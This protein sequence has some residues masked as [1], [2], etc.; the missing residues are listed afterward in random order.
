MVGP[1]LRTGMDISLGRVLEAARER[2]ATLTPEV[3][4]YV[5]LLA[6]RQVEGDH[7]RV[8]ADSVLLD[9]AGDVLVVRDDV[10]SER[11]VEAALR[12]LLGALVGLCASP[13]PAIAA[14]AS[15]E[16][17]GDLRALGDELSAALIP[18]N[19]AAAHR[20]LARLYRETR[21][22]Q[23]HV[24]DI[25]L[26]PISEQRPEPEGGELEIDVVV[27]GEESERERASAEPPVPS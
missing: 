5:I 19:H 18:I 26:P 13:P 4:G 21:R 24:T 14:V 25:A 2:R 1:S 16:A 17:S 15:R 20:A 3:A 6:T 11:S 12:G 10:A 9:E 8:S 7:A 22:A 23:G 27:E